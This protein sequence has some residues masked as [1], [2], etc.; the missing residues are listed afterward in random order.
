MGI[1]THLKNIGTF[2]FW[3]SGSAKQWGVKKSDAS[4]SKFMEETE[5]EV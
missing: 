4:L 2:I 5:S 3:Y 1:L